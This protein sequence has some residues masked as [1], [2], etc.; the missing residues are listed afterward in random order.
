MKLI[1]RKNEKQEV[2]V[3]IRNQI[4]EDPFSYVAMIKSLVANNKFEESEFE[5]GITEEEKE[6]VNKMLTKINEAIAKNETVVK[7]DLKNETSS[8]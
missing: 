7:N 4:A 5:D 2:S 3:L 6:S 8:D 1:F